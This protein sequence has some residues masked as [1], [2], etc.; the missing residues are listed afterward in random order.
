MYPDAVVDS[1]RR[2]L[3]RRVVGCDDK[4]FV[5]GSAQMLQDAQN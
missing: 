2:G 4:G 5:T 1:I 3:T